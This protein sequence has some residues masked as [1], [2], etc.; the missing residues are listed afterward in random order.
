MNIILEVWKIKTVYS[1]SE[2]CADL[3]LLFVEKIKY[4]VFAYFY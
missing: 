2:R 3:L 1:L 4:N